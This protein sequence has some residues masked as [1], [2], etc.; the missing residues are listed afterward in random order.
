MSKEIYHPN[1]Y[2]SSIKNIKRGLRA[3][4]Q[5]L[6]TLENH[7]GDAKNVANET[8]KPYGVVLHHLKL[9]E[10]EGIAERK[11][12]RPHVWMLTGVGQ[13]RLVNKS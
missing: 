12:S 10:S 9:L 2:L 11:G 1:A 13:K 6:N 8:G 3:R 4:T 5:I 7:A